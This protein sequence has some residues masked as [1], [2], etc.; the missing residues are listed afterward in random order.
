MRL[1][2]DRVK[3]RRQRQTMA[4]AGCWDEAREGGTGCGKTRRGTK[5]A[6]GTSQ[7]P[8]R[9]GK[10]TQ[11]RGATTTCDGWDRLDELLFDVVNFFG[12][13]SGCREKDG[14]AMESQARWTVDDGSKVGVWCLTRYSAYRGYGALRISKAGDGDGLGGWLLETGR[15]LERTGRRRINRLQENLVI[16]VPA[17]RHTDG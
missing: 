6:I 4:V 7:R 12:I 5:R 17:N 2:D 8:G 16:C 10:L 1:R 13:G 3:W 15:G 14:R 11:T 9:A